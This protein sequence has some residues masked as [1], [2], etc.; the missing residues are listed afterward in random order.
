M[1]DKLRVE[2]YKHA[3]REEDIEEVVKVLRSTFL[4]TGPKTKHFEAKLAEYLQQKYVVGVTSCTAGLFLSLK[5]LGIGPGDEVITTPLSFIATSN[6]ILEAGATPIFVD[7]EPE[8][9]NI[10]L[11]RVEAAITSKTKAV[12][13]VHL[14][15]QMVDMKKLSAICKSRGL[16]IIEDAA[17]SLESLREG[18][19]PGQLGTTACFSFY[20][21]KNLTCGE[22]GAISTDDPEVYD[23]LL[24]LRLHGM[25]KSAAERYSKRYEHW[26]M[27]MLGYKANLPDILSAVMFHQIDRLGHQLQSREAI[28]KRY[29]E[30]FSPLPQLDFPKVQPDSISARHLF[31]LWVPRGFRDSALAELQ[32]HHIGV[33]VNFRPI[34]LMRFYRKT[35]GFQPGSFP[36]AEEIGERTLTLPMYPDMPKEKVDRVI[37]VVTELAQHWHP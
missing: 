3:V 35:M 28:C 25:T 7:V 32:A 31:T 8:T 21:T 34:H 14:Y 23:R 4:T 20:A 37:E 26:D 16:H 12:M 17:H 9:G 1:D 33:A 15:G 13:P 24:Q 22:G 10:D 30:A 29:E 5:A 19:R 18:I 11:A 27:D 6:T 2:F 36:I